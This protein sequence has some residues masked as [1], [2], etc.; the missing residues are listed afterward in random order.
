VLRLWRNTYKRQTVNIFSKGW[1]FVA[2]D[3]RYVQE[4]KWNSLAYP[5]SNFIQTPLNLGI[6][7][8]ARSN[9]NLESK[10][11]NAI[12]LAIASLQWNNNNKEIWHTHYVRRSWFCHSLLSLFDSLGRVV[13][14]EDII[15]SENNPWSGSYLRPRRNRFSIYIHQRLTFRGHV[16][17]SYKSTRD[18]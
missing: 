5:K 1:Q 15:P 18:G 17:C 2:I 12:H 9:W 11:Q 13:E 16:N 8:L 14:S 3:P 4:M 10:D 7:S 6:E